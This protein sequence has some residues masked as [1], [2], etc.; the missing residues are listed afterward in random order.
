MR[1]DR[2]RIKE[3][4]KYLPCQEGTI[5]WVQRQDTRDILELL[6][7]LEKD[8]EYHV[9]LPL[10]L[11]QLI[12]MP[13]NRLKLAIYC[14]ELILPHHEELMRFIKNKKQEHSFEYQKVQGIK[15]TASEW[16]LSEDDMRDLTKRLSVIVWFVARSLSG[17]EEF[18]SSVSRIYE[19]LTGEEDVVWLVEQII[20]NV[21]LID[22][23]ISPKGKLYPKVIKRAKEILRSEW[24]ESK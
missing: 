12:T 2:K 3:L 4:A 22:Q 1:I 5:S 6:D 11:I 18:S 21:L 23:N 13:Q 14:T 9:F 8:R 24:D 19:L 15:E 20:R 17:S 10:V 16:L 7:N